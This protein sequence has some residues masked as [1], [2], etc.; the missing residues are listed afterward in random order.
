MKEMLRNFVG[1]FVR[2]SGRK[3][4][5]GVGGQIAR[6][7]TESGFLTVATAMETFRAF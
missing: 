5:T 1:A 6:T 4:G 7:R 2:F 3:L